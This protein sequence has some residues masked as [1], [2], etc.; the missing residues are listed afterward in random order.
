MVFITAVFQVQITQ[1]LVFIASEKVQDCAMTSLALRLLASIQLSFPL[2]AYIGSWT[3]IC[4]IFVKQRN[5]LFYTINNSFTVSYCSFTYKNSLFLIR[6]PNSNEIS[7]YAAELFTVA[8]WE[9]LQKYR[10]SYALHRL[11]LFAPHDSHFTQSDILTSSL[12]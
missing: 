11:N 2:L 12:R 10:T 5:K 1:K 9:S 6:K 7:S 3:L 4:V 8:K